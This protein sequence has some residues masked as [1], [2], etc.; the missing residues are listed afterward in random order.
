L[1]KYSSIF[2]VRKKCGLAG[3]GSVTSAASL[4]LDIKVSFIKHGIRSG[5]DE[6]PL[7]RDMGKMDPDSETEDWLFWLPCRRIRG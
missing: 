4:T 3:Y 6:S 5:N 7:S 1:T 2:A